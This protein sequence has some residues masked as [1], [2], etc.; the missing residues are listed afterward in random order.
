MES[1]RGTWTD[2]RLDEFAARVDER[3]DAV[4]KRFDAVDTRLGT[5]E[6]RLGTVE[7]RLDGFDYQFGEV[8]RVLAK[9][10]VDLR[11]VKSELAA[12]SRSMLQFCGVMVAAQMATV[13]TLIAIHG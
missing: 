1:M 6:K 12:N 7:K 3:F 5:V 9:V 2:T 11:E 13:A 10:D 4:D 8:R